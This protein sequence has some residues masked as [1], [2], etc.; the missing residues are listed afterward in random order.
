MDTPIKGFS[1]Q[2]GKMVKP[3]PLP[4][5]G[6][7]LRLTMKQNR[8]GCKPFLV[9]NRVGS[10]LT[11]SRKRDNGHGTTVNLSPTQIGDFRNLMI[12]V[13]EKRIMSL[14]VLQGNGRTLDP[15]MEAY[16]QFGQH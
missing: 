10:D 4:K 9:V 5:V 7:S 2:I 12:P 8:S 1:V 13:S 15:D 3:K 16:P 11:T 14:W 6:I